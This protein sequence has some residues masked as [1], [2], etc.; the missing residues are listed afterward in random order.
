MNIL[1]NS[2]KDIDNQKLMDYISGQLSDQDRHEVERWMVDNEFEREALEGLEGMTGN[3]KRELN[4]YVEQL[5]KDLNHYLQK[6]KNQR[7]KRKIREA[8]WIYV[9][10]LL[11]LALAILA[12]V[13]IHRLQHQH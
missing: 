1:S 13:V 6:K 5:N 4:T 12:Y 2:N 7:Q 3:S 8:P 10:I 9:A 11:I